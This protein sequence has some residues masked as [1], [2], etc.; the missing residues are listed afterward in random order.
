MRLRKTIRNLTEP[1]KEQFESY[2]AKKLDT[3]AAIVDKYYPE[4]DA[5][6]VDATMEKFDKHTAFS[7]KLAFE[8]PHGR[9]TTEETK[10]TITEV[11]DLTA[12][13][14][15]RQLRDHFATRPTE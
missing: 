1:E 8:F 3:L 11:V 2:L 12:E 13:R 15:E 9:F 5:L 7:L 10:H 4:E 6:Q 14:M